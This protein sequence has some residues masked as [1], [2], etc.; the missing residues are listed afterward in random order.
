M[1]RAT[2]S[3]LGPLVLV[4]LSAQA[5]PPAGGGQQRPPAQQGQRSPAPQQNQQRPAPRP[6]AQRQ[7]D[8]RHRQASPVERYRGPDGYRPGQR[9]PQLHQAPGFDPRTYRHNY[10]AERRYRV[11]PYVRPHGWYFHRWIFGDILPAIFWTQSYW[12][13]DYWL[14]GLPI[15]PVGYVW[16][17]Y[18]NDALLVDRQTGE[19]LQV[20][21]DIFY[22]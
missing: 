17:R 11:P 16:V 19:V 5:H 8:Q 7:H 15:P 3:L 2:T 9:P 20:I 12:I 1:K 14:Y 21:Y 10:R 13:A 4:M 18:G 22:W 6:E